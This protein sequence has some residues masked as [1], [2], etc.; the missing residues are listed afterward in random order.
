VA[1]STRRSALSVVGSALP[2]AVAPAPTIAPATTTS[3]FDVFAQ[4]DRILAQ[5]S[6]LTAQAPTYAQFGVSLRSLSQQIA[7]V[8]QQSTINTN[9]IN[10]VLQL[11]D[12][13]ITGMGTIANQNAII[14]RL[15][16]IEAALAPT[17][18][19]TVGLDTT[20]IETESQPRPT[21]AGP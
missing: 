21:R 10:S 16:A 18:P 7:A 15:V 12:A 8:Q 1:Q 3:I 9:L 4:V 17:A 19:K 13:I 6:V 11:I 14:Q 20:I 2:T 5:L